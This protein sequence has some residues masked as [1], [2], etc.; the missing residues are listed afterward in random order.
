MKNK[1]KYLTVTGIRKNSR[2]TVISVSSS[3]EKSLC[4]LS[5][6]LNKQNRKERELNGNQK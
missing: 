3:S 6:M 2:E 4:W 5:W 1:K